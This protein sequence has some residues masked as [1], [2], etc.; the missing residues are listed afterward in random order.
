MGTV[1]QQKS[2]LYNSSR[3]HLNMIVLVENVNSVYFFKDFALNTLNSFKLLWFTYFPV[4]NVSL[5]SRKRK[6]VLDKLF[7]FEKCKQK[8]QNTTTV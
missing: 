6:T 7:P 4:S 3:F 5:K 8:N 2:P 1:S